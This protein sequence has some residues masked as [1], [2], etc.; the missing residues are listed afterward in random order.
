MN[1]GAFGMHAAPVLQV[2]V[3]GWVAGGRGGPGWL[4]GWVAGWLG[5]WVA[6]WLAGWRAGLAGELAGPASLGVLVSIDKAGETQ[7]H[8][9]RPRCRHMKTADMKKDRK[10]IAAGN[11]EK[12]ARASDIL[13]M[14]PRTSPFHEGSGVST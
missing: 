1:E 2:A 11:S 7:E 8:R 9:P 4:G 14:F 5:G 12:D 6:G 10:E 13:D 3:A